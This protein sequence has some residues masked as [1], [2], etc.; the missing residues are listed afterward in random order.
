MWL[1][2]GPR[3][4][5]TPKWAG[6]SHYYG[7]SMGRKSYVVESQEAGSQDEDTESRQTLGGRD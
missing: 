3:T 1:R 7:V 6:I 5:R 2:V 4:T